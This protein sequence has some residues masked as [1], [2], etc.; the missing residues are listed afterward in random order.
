MVYL[1]VEMHSFMAV[2][3]PIAIAKVA[4][5]LEDVKG[6]PLGCQQMAKMTSD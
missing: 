1:W 3:G 5:N 2:V 6:D 4:M